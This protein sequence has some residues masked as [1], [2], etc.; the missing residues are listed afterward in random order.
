MIPETTRIEDWESLDLEFSLKYFKYYTVSNCENECIA[1]LTFNECQ[2]TRYY[3][4]SKIHE[5]FNFII[6]HFNMTFL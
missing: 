4:P 6:D 5:H 3:M 1:N 2:C